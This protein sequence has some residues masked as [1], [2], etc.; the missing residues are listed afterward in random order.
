VASSDPGADVLD[1]ECAPATIW[2]AR[3]L[4]AGAGWAQS[5]R[6]STT[7]LAAVALDIRDVPMRGDSMR[8][9]VRAGLLTGQVLAEARVFVTQD[10]WA[11]FA[12]DP[13]IGVELDQTY[14]IQL[15]GSGAWWAC[16]DTD[17]YA[18][19]FAFN[20]GA[21]ILPVRDFNFRTYAPAEHWQQMGWSEWKRRLV[22][23]GSGA[24]ERGST[25]SR[26]DGGRAR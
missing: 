18:R 24:Q 3:C 20:C 22:P 10:G 25:K 17:P 7:P 2:V 5:F 13:E 23:G 15:I 1:Q 8:V 16:S 26:V 4:R 9:C 11:R 12:F 21:E 19:G 14:T 6:P